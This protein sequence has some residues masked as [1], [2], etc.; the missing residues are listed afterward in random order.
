MPKNAAAIVIGAGAAGLAAAGVLAR[1]G[2]DVTI[3]EARNRVGGRIHTVDTLDGKYAIELGAEFVHGGNR[4]L[5][6]LIKTA[7]LHT[8]KVTSKRCLIR[9]NLR[10]LIE[11]M[12]IRIAQ[13]MKSIGPENTGTF[14]EW[15]RQNETKVT[16]ADRFLAARY[17]EGFHAAPLD[18]MSA[19]TLFRA[20]QQPDEEQYRIVGGY[21]QIITA[22]QNEWP[23]ERVAL[24][25][26]AP[27]RSLVWST[28]DVRIM[29][30]DRI[31]WRAR[32][33]VITVPLG[34]LQ[35]PKENPRAIFFTSEL[36]GKLKTVNSFGWG[37]VV[38][39]VI[40]F[41]DS[42]WDDAILP[43]DL[44][45]HQG[46]DFGF[47]QSDISAFPIWWSLSPAPVLVGWSGGLDA[48][49]LINYTAERT[50]EE[51]LGALCSL[52]GCA[53]TEL[54]SRIVEWQTY[55]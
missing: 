47:V 41:C 18:R 12:E 6:S 37:K 40:Q 48:E 26:N 4:R 8:E 23:K 25:L 1:G 38:R 10:E 7:G 36:S 22:L 42:F 32:A 20:T 29:L 44:R 17:V 50:F 51:A 39:I 24:E 11:D 53:G 5:W 31:E 3:L 54:S 35:L 45:A 34:V 28:S 19:Q 30:S 52:F 2:V 13:V 49:E 14:G 16:K 55:N 43:G 15:L 27:V 21:G 46:R 9:Q 33:V